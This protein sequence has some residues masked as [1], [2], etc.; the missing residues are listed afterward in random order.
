[1]RILLFLARNAFRARNL[2]FDA[3]ITRFSARGFFSLRAILRFAQDDTG[4]V[5]A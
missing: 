5:P 4:R 2:T 3:L 1:M